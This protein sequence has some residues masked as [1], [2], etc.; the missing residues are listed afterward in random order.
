MATEC[1]VLLLGQQ[2]ET[3]QTESSWPCPC[4]ACTLLVLLP[5][6]I[7]GEQ[8]KRELKGS[9]DTAGL[10]A[11]FTVRLST[12]KCVRAKKKRKGSG[13]TFKEK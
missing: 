13:F 8:V 5:R 2:G 7:G 12:L 11:H 4:S 1:S 10:G 3:G 9:G 6:E